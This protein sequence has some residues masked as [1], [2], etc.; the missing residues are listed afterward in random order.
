MYYSLLK[1]YICPAI[2]T[3]LGRTLVFTVRLLMHTQYAW[4]CYR[5]L[6]VCLSAHIFVPYERHLYLKFWAKLTAFI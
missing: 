2:H 1:H 4:S 6:T 5:N 3:V